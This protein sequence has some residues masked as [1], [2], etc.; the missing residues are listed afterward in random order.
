MRHFPHDCWSEILFKT[1]TNFRSEWVF[2]TNAEFQHKKFEDTKG[3]IR[4]RI[5]KNRQHNV[6]NQEGKR[7][8]RGNYDLQ[9]ITQK[10]KHRAIKSKTKQKNK[11]ERV[12]LMYYGRI[13]CYSC[14]KPADKLWMRKGPTCYYVK[15]NIPVVI[16]TPILR[17]G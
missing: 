10:T 13:T 4:S 17:S 14:Y 3:V 2:M 11:K 16:L 15:W 9:S 7:R 8:Q 12:E 5:S 1:K 6:I